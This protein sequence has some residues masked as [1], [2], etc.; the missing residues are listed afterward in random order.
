MEL[1]DQPQ[2]WRSLC[3]STI[4][5]VLYSDAKGRERLEVA[6]AKAE[7]GATDEVAIEFVGD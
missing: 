2:T 5:C 4:V 6:Q 7:R 1:V 3:N